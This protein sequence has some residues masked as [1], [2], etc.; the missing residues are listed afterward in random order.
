VLQVVPWPFFRH[1]TDGDLQAI[2]QR[3]GPVTD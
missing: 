2:V 1:M 3:P